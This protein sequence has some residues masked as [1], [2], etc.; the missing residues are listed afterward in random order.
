[1]FK[2]ETD[3]TRHAKER[4]A[5]TREAAGFATLVRKEEA[6]R[7]ELRKAEEQLKEAAKVKNGWLSDMSKAKRE[8]AGKAQVEIELEVEKTSVEVEFE[9]ATKQVRE[10]TMQ[11]I[12]MKEARIASQRAWHCEQRRDT[13]P[14]GGVGCSYQANTGAFVSVFLVW[15]QHP[16]HTICYRLQTSGLVTLLPPPFLWLWP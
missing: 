1:M 10:L 2:E 5:E 12:A 3:R 16:Y 11:A 14:G 9:A 13:G 8:L 6:V 4:E 15:K 7:A